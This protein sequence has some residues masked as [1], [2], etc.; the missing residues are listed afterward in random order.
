MHPTSA[1]IVTVPE[2]EPAVGAHRDRLDSA[3]RLG[4]PA[5]V[6]VL[7]PFVPPSEIDSAVME[8]LAAAVASVPRSTVAFDATR[9]FGTDVLWLAPRP[10]T[11]F[12]TLTAAVSAA[13]PEHPPYGGAHDEVVPHLTVGHNAPYAVL[14]QAEAAVLPLLPVEAEIATAALWCGGDDAA[15]WSQVEAFPLG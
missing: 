1:V 4:V 10:G 15:S 6:T 11:V 8:R 7:F 14:C 9:W 3:A 13:F 2:A 5:H 12:E